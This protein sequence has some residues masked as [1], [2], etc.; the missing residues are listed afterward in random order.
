MLFS[1]QFIISIFSVQNADIH[2]NT[3]ITFFKFS[4][5]L[6]TTAM[7]VRLLWYHF[8]LVPYGEQNSQNSN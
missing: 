7:A 3:K 6:A 8:H 1:F 2:K 4:A 5:E